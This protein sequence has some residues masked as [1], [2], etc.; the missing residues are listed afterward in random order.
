MVPVPPSV[1]LSRPLPSWYD[2]GKVGVFVHWG[3]YS[4]PS[5]GGG[6][7]ACE[8]FWENWRGRREPWIIDFVRDNFLTEFMYPDFSPDF[9]AELYQPWEWVELFEQAGAKWVWQ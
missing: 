1:S 7:S 6:R 8:W 5:Y 2:Q 9:K 4:V 3:L